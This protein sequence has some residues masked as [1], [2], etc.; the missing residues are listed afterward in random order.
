MRPCHETTENNTQATSY[1]LVSKLERHIKT[2]E[3]KFKFKVILKTRIT[4]IRLYLNI[5][6]K[7]YLSNIMNAV[8]FLKSILTFNLQ[9]LNVKKNQ[10]NITPLCFYTLVQ[11]E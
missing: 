2:K 3:L 8:C 10:I 6:N 5:N 7:K 9:K 1:T 4:T 11:A